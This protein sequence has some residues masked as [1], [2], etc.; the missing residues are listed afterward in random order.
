MDKKRKPI[1]DKDTMRDHYDLSKMKWRRNPYAG[2]IKHPITIRVEDGG[3]VY[4]KQLSDVLDTPEIR[5]H[6]RRLLALKEKE[7]GAQARLA[8]IVADIG[9]ELV[10][11]KAALDRTADKTAW[12]RWLR[13]H[14]QFVVQ[15]ADNYMRVSRLRK[16]IP[17]AFQKFARLSPTALYL[18]AALPEALIAKL[19]ADPRLPSPETGE[20]TPLDKMSSR[21]LTL[22][23]EML[24]G[25][26][27]GG[28]PAKSA[29]PAQGTR[30]VRAREAIDRG[31]ALLADIQDVN[32]GGGQLASASK[33]DML[34]MIEELREA[35]LRWKA[36]VTP[37]KGRSPA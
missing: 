28:K 37:E 25:G 23:L 27:K 8:D 17:S 31:R 1:N 29:M 11:T 32:A 6:T 22:A 7:R 4:I 36:W 18:I 16:K 34:D 19:A 21:D 14:V 15:S 13:D 10:A 2:K 5:R 26:R 33:R 20:L 9:D 12:L 35:V 24:R 3:R 30:D